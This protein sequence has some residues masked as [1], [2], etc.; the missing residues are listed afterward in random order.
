MATLNVTPL[1]FPET[2]SNIHCALKKGGRGRR[3]TL[4]VPL[5]WLGGVFLLL[6]INTCCWKHNES[7]SIKSGAVLVLDGHLED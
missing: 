3:A 4:I 1:I 7:L 6:L 5:G 2:R